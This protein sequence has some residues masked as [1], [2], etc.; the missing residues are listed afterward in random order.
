MGRGREFPQPSSPYNRL[1]SGYQVF[2][3]AVKWPGRGVNHPLPSSPEVKERVEIST[4]PLSLHRMLRGEYLS[5]LHFTSK[6]SPPTVF[7]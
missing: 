7:V 2:F 1:Y 4:S 5:T 6:P 3:P